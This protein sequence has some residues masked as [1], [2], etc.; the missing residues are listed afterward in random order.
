M[1]MQKPEITKDDQLL[2]IVYKY[3]ETE[4]VF[5]CYETEGQV[6]LLC[7]YLF[8]T[9]EEVSQIVPLDKEKLL[10]ELNQV[11]LPSTKQVD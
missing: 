5:R 1:K 6:C 7:D 4:A 8:C 10:S 3:P 9:L 2:D 11:L